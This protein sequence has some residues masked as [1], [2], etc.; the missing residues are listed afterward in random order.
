[1]TGM[2]QVDD[3]CCCCVRLRRNEVTE[4]GSFMS[5]SVGLVRGNEYQLVIL[6]SVEEGTETGSVALYA[7]VDDSDLLITSRNIE[8]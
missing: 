1:M 7:T 5:Q 8:E 2:R 4:F 3:R 6:D